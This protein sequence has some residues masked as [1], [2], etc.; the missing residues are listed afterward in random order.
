MSDDRELRFRSAIELG[1][2][3]RDKQVSSLELTKLYLDALEQR[4]RKLNAVAELSRETALS[5]AKQAD[6]ELAAGKVRSVLHGVPWGAK[7]LLATKDF[8]TRWGSPAHADQRFDHD[9]TVVERLRHHGCVMVAKL[10]MIELAGGGGYENCAAS[11]TGAC[12]CPFDESR[13]AGGSSSGSGAAVGDGLVGFAIGSETWGSITVPAA[14]C[15]VTGLR[16]TYGRVPRKGAMA[17]SFTMDKLGPMAR[18]ADDCATILE[19]ISGH[20]PKDPSST[21]RSFEYSIEG[22][23]QRGRKLKL[24]VLPHD[25]DRHKAPNAQ[26]RFG[27]AL[28]VLKKLGHSVGDSKLYNA[29]YA[30]AASTIVDSEGAAA[31]QDLIR[32]EKFDLLI[33]PAQKAGLLAGLAIPAADYL[34]AMQIRTIAGPEAVKVFDQ[35]DVLVAPTLLHVAPPADKPLS[36]TF[37][38]MGGNGAAGNLLGWPSI[39]VPMGMGEDDLP[40]GLELIGA[41]YDEV[42]IL[43]VA[44]AFQRETDHHRAKPKTD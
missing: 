42:T 36:E 25:Y 19:L 11:L 33:D 27:E 2:L 1:K 15:N 18:S 34:R 21:Q 43:S 7:D 24:G 13:W 9:A 32:S 5:Q 35:F 23:R 6:E 10:A 22:R 39:S 41:P 20:D 38:H 26:K 8:P 40:L 30:L 4:G 37:N 28:D 29:P 14:F 31:F 12:K 16:P 3:I 44:I 17:L